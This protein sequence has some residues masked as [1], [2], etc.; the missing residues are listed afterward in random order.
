[1][2]DVS[3]SDKFLHATAGL[4]RVRKGEISVAMEGRWLMVLGSR[5]FSSADARR[6]R[7]KE[8]NGIQR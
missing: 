3:E 7:L 4:T 5:E 2:V 1:M 8:L 6:Q